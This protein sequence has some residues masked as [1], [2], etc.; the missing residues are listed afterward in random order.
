MTATTPPTDRAWIRPAAVAGAFYPAG[1]GELTEVIDAEMARA[2]SRV[3]VTAGAGA[4]IETAGTAATAGTDLSGRRPKALIVPHAGYVYSGP[5]AASAYARLLPWADT[6]ERVVL[7]G[8]A[9]RVPV[10][11][12]AVSSAES[13]E[14]P[15]GSV[16]VDDE[17]RR[18]VLALPGVEIDD[19][20]HGPEHSLEVEL[21]FLQRILTRPFTV[22]PVVVGH[23]AA[24]EVAAVLDAVWNGDGT[25]V[26]ISSDLSHYEDH[27]AA[28]V[29]DRRTA[30][31]ILAGHLDDIGPH[32]A[33]GAFPLRGLLALAR[34]RRLDIE[35]VDLRN[36]G[37][38][39]G[40]ADRV[41]GYGSFVL[42]ASVPAGQ[43]GWDDP[44]E[45]PAP[46]PDHAV[47]AGTAGAGRAM[48][49]RSGAGGGA[50]PGERADY[51]LTTSAPPVTGEDLTGD[52]EDLILGVA[53]EAVRARFEHRPPQRPEQVPERLRGPAATFVTLRDGRRLL[54]CIG[55][56]EARRPLLEDVADNAVGAAF[57]DPRMPGLTPF[58][59]GRMSIHVS[60]LT[61][62]ERLAV[63]SRAELLAALTPGIDGLLVESGD[64][65]GTFLPSVW[66]QIP[67]ADDFLAHLWRKAGLAPGSWPVGLQVWRYRTVE[68]GDE[69]PRPPIRSGTGD[70]QD[71]QDVP[72]DG[73]PLKPD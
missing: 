55:S 62:P 69:G 71:E 4:P 64:R 51:V 22:L 13:W 40:P 58:E 18:R 23:A 50:G 41:V 48:T 67:K 42:S 2:T 44:G 11:S 37:D 43:T 8:P 20:A 9:H 16:P 68:L 66:E 35:L 63:G 59:F 61:G 54:G 3:R 14:T 52:E 7:L 33:C 57:R 47:T 1:A 25:L 49:E 53:A 46:A 26:V 6:I 30:D 5:V 12:M 29:H 60:V 28:T 36:S 21:P 15:L 10:R 17:A 70:E 38:T 39:A 19:R 72:D 45:T 24:A 32:D 73:P 34:R 65:R 56:I 27:G 31:H